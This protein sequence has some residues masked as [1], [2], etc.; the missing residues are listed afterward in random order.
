MRAFGFG[1]GATGRPSPHASFP[2][3]PLTAPGHLAAFSTAPYAAFGAQKLAGAY[4]GP[5]FRLRRSSDGATLDVGAQAGGD[6]PDYAAIAVWAG[7][8]TLTVATL[9]DQTGNGRHLTQAVVANQP[10]F[11]PAQATGHVVPILIDGYGRSSSAGLPQAQI[12]KTLSVGGLS[13]DLTATS[14]FMTVAPKASYNNTAYVQGTDD[15]V[16]TGS[17]EYF[18]Q[19]GNLAIRSAAASETGNNAAVPLS[20]NTIG[21]TDSATAL[22]IYAR[23]AVRTLGHTRSSTA[24]PRLTVG[25]SLFGGTGF[26][27]MFKLFG[28]VV[29]PA[30]LGTADSGSVIASMNTAF[31][32]PSAY[33]YGV[34]F[35]GDSIMEGSGG[36][37]LR[38]VPN[39]LQGQITRRAEMFN[40]A[41]HGQTMATDYATRTK[42]ASLFRAGVANLAFIEAGTND[43]GSATTG[44]N[45]YANAA[46]PYVAY[47]KG[48]GY[49]V[50]ICTLL[51]RSGSAGWTAAME[52]ERGNYNA[53]V[54]ANSAG[55]D[56]VLDLT[57]NPVMGGTAA[58]ADT[59][60]YVDKLHPTT[61][62]Y[63]W[64]AGAAGG[65]YAGP[66]T[67]FA[68]LQQM[69]S[70]AP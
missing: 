29:Y 56:Y 12:A 58:C 60:L 66:Y 1:F 11:D 55:A 20:P 62:G 34:L 46:T 36:L 43:L 35:T 33:D 64:L 10:S 24:M 30:T 51:P 13:L 22:N 23:S 14:I 25:T 47:L 31:A 52:T 40:T 67:Y 69:L 70:Q 41:V 48:L 53:L 19:N 65:T 21:F 27:A 32:V 4:A 15:G 2:A 68:A 49:K 5:L 17:G 28:M 63:R 9:Y 8:A 44:A 57:R 16:T 18:H 3:A 26:N 6:Y 7:S 37:L 45:L 54:V 39:W 38:S 42:A 50:A 59:T 61:L